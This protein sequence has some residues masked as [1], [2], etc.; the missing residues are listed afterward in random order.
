MDVI[1]VEHRGYAA[2]T[3]EVLM[4]QLWVQMT[5]CGPA[6]RLRLC[7]MLVE[8]MTDHHGLVF[9]LDLLGENAAGKA[10]SSAEAASSDALL[11]QRWRKRA[12]IL[13]RAAH[14]VEETKYK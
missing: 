7:R 3:A 5:N 1:N 6:D 4:C 2:N 14:A 11:G 13:E 9:W 10:A 8:H 12:A